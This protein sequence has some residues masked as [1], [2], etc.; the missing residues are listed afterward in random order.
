MKCPECQSRLV[1]Q[2]GQFIIKNDVVT[3]GFCLNEKCA[4]YGKPI[5][6]IL[7]RKLDCEE[8]SLG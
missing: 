6:F 4:T 5:R 7:E 3:H 8:N 1:M 2:G